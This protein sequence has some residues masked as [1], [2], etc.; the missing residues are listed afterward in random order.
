MQK[1]EGKKGFEVM[2]VSK[3]FWHLNEAALKETKEIF[4][5]PMHPKFMM[6]IVT[7]LSRCDKPKEF[8]S[9]IKKEK[10]IDIWPKIR[11][12]WVQRVR[13]SDFRDWWQ[14]I[15][16]QLMEDN[17]RATMNTKGETP[18]FF[19]K[20]GTLVREARIE[21]GLSQRQL[22]QAIGMKQPDIS[23]IEEGKKNITLFTLMRLCKILEI[24]KIDME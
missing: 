5:N 12:Y 20:V 17:Q 18:Q 9:I 21:K 23:R 16:E 10:F 15:Y 19:K 1:L 3:Y 13:I 11:T 14:T 7:L 4:K 2:K 24:K 22:S 6:R 8:F